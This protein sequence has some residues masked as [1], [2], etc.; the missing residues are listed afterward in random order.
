MRRKIIINIILCL[1]KDYILRANVYD[2]HD[3]WQ[4]VRKIDIK[5]F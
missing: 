4:T 3:V 1:I 5:I 2:V